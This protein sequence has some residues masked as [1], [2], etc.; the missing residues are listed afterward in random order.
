M[1]AAKIALFTEFAFFAILARRLD[2]GER[3][4]GSELAATNLVEVVAKLCS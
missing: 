1:P 2:V 4:F 3:T